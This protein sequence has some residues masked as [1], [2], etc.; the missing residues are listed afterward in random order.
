MTDQ[1][2]QQD[3]LWAFGSG[4]SDWGSDSTTPHSYLQPQARSVRPAGASARQPEGLSSG[5]LGAVLDGLAPPPALWNKIADQ[6]RE[7][8]VIKD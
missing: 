4:D 6:L 3:E 1:M 2:S 7:D 8:G 5:G